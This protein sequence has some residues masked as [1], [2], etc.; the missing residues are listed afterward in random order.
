MPG[1]RMSL[2]MRSGTLSAT[3]TS[4]S[5]PERAVATSNPSARRHAAT[6]RSKFGSSSTTSSRL[7]I[8]QLLY[9]ARF[10]S[11]DRQPHGEHGPARFARRRAF[12]GDRPAQLVDDAAREVQ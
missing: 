5:A 8:S 3:R 1:I 6:A 9:L 4:A 7:D 2:T 10:V 12:D 11:P